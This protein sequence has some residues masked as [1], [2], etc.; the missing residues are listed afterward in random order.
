MAGQLC[1]DLRDLLDLQ[2]GVVA[3]WQANAMA[4]DPDV[5][6]ARLRS[7]RWRRLH[8]GI[9]TAFTGRP[10]RESE[11]WAAVLRA[12]PRAVLSHQTAAELDGFAP[13]PSRLIHVTVPLAQHMAAVPGIVVHRSG[14]LEL[15]RHPLRTPPRT[16]IEET[17][18]DLTQLA[19]SF[20]DAFG[21]ISRPCGKR[22]TT[23]PL[24]MRAMQSRAKLRWRTELALALADVA[25]GVLSPLEYRYV[26]NVERPHGL[27]PAQR[28]ALIS[29]W[30]RRQYLDNLY[31]EFGLGVE[32][33]GQ[34]SHGAEERW[35]DIGRDNA[36]AADGILVLRYGWGD[37]HDRPCQVAV[38]VG[39]AAVKR[40][41][42]GVLRRCG[43][44]CCVARR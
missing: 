30:P 8:R 33:D 14:R 35:R 25:D 41:W 17:S 9:Y 22:L 6:T 42:S 38:Q 36:L 23:A 32:L 26:H 19:N 10:G 21:W 4:V 24:L 15:T 2:C 37:V 20:D 12:G 31:Q 18:L 34:A 43:P 7:G 27:P 11:L 44:T 1:D 5:I 3:R 39:G 16:R 13:G 40:G 28:Q 29:R